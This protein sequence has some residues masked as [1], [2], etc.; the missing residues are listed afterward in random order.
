MKFF[1]VITLCSTSL[2]VAQIPQC[3]VTVSPADYLLLYTRDNF[4]DSLLPATFESQGSTWN[5]AKI[6][7]K[8]HSTRYYPKKGYSVKLPSSNLFQGLGTATFNAM[9][10]DKSFLRE[11]LVWDL[12]NDMGAVASRASYA[13]LTINGVPKLLYLLLDKPDKLPV[14]LL[15]RQERK[16]SGSIS[17]RQ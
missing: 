6:K 3:N 5:G 1:V 7:F 2:L 12:F 13:R 16:G 11:K 4:S 9:Y 14:S 8:G 10:T 15:T 17:D